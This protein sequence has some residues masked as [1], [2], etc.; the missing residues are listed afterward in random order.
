VSDAAQRGTGGNNTNDVREPRELERGPNAES[1]DLDAI[2]AK[3]IYEV[4]E[5][6]TRRGVARF[7]SALVQ[8]RCIR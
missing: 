4:G 7:D 8:L 2:N 3:K 1:T 5:R 6:I